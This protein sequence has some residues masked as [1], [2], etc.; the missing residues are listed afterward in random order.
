MIY[1]ISTGL[2]AAM[3]ALS[4]ASY[5]FHQATIEGVR[6]LGFPDFFRIELAVLKLIAIP[7]LLLPLVPPNVKEWAYAGV[8]L[9][10]VTAI[11]AH[12]VHR[13]PIG[14]ILINIALLGLLVAS[15]ASFSR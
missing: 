15:N 2:V 11:V 5:L 8:A 6:D 12:S 13:D 3:L 10:L 7:V 9:F 1:W 14:L 4:A